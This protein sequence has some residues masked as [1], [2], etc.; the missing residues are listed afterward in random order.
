MYVICRFYLRN[1]Q[2]FI[3]VESGAI[4]IVSKKSKLSNVMNLNRADRFF[5]DEIIENQNLYED[6][7]WK[8]SDD[9]IRKRFEEYFIRLCCVA[10][11]PQILNP[12]PN[13]NLPVILFGLFS[14][15]I[16]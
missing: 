15:E 14:F 5:M 9:W 3:Q 13:E 8:G 11:I 16:S 12:D 2:V 6:G 4:E 1:S 10:S 7:T